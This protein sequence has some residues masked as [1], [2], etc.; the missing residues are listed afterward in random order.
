M[1]KISVYN[2]FSGDICVIKMTGIL[3]GKT[4]QEV[5]GEIVFKK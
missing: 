1:T 4:V 3:T 5:P 2:N